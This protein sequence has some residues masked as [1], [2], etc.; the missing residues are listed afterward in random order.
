MRIT[1]NMLVNNMINYISNSETRM[2]TYQRQ[3]ATG[4]KVSVPS[5]DPVVAAR[6]LK[7]RTDVSEIE[8][9]QT[10]VKDAQSWTDITEST[11]GDMG[12][13]IQRARELAVQGANGSNTPDDTQKIA[14]EI[15]Q[16]KTQLIHLGNT[17]YAGR[18][19]F[20]GF[21]TDKPL[22]NDDGTFAI[23]VNTYTNPS[24]PMVNREDIKFETG[25]GDNININVQ[26]GDLF[27]IGGNAS[28]VDK[29]GI[30]VGN[31]LTFPV[32]I[33]AG[34]QNL[35]IT[36]DGINDATHN[37]TITIP[38][39]SYANMAALTTAINGQ[40]ALVPGM[41]ATPTVSAGAGTGTSGS[42]M[43]VF[44]SATLGNSSSVSI[45]NNQTTS[46]AGVA[47]GLT[48]PVQIKGSSQKSSMIQDFDDFITAL[49]SGN[50]SAVSGMITK[51]ENDLS[52][53]LRVRADIGARQNRLDLTSNRLDNNDTNFTKLMSDNEDVDMAATIMNLQ[54][55]EN[56][57][58]A[59]LSGGAR[60]I[61]PSLVDFLK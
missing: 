35:H 14:L 48:L 54:N 17:T 24:A 38:A 60:I 21:S 4:Q 41:P 46:T 39:A 19:I 52:N 12:N 25:I 34:N 2:S 15:G 36:V 42:N 43:L 49:N 56:V 3:M 23:N 59:S 31:A 40:I 57:Y 33:A 13:V 30:A 32:T 7:L 16:L 6:A 28:T 27:N 53:V 37:F 51:M 26:G 44:T 9:Y 45:D 10:N 11:L 61:Q 29:A 55:E 50:T 18:Y 8:Q 1:N 20:S 47:L 58:R 5:D 22:L